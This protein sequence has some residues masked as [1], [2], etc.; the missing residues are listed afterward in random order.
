DRQV[1]RRVGDL[2]A[3]RRRR[4]GVRDEERVGDGLAGVERTGGGQRLDERDVGRGRGGAAIADAVGVVRGVRIDFGGR[5]G[6]AVVE[7]AGGRDRRR[8]IDRGVR[9]RRQRGDRARQRRA[10]PRN[11]AEGEV[12][13][14]VGY[15]D[16]RRRGRAGIRDDERVRDGL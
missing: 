1:R 5:G 12:R 3:G 8:N 10:G 13:R 2:D 6:G 7:R 4:A 9:A 11:R 15:L 16:R 14:R